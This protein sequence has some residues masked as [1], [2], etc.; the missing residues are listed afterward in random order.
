MKKYIICILTLTIV[1]LACNNKNDDGV[2]STDILQEEYYDVNIA[3]A[4]Q[5]FKT[6]IEKQISLTEVYNSDSSIENF[7]SLQNQW[8]VCAKYFSKVRAYNVVAVKNLFYDVLIYNYEI[9]TESIETNITEQVIFDSTYFNK[10]SSVT[11][12]LGA[13]EYLLYNEQNSNTAFSLLTE[14]SFRKD[15]MLGVCENVLEKTNLLVDFWAGY[16][17][18]FINAT[19][20]SCTT[21]ARCVSFNQ[22]INIIDVI[23]VSKLGKP[24]GFESSDNIN[25]KLL[26]AYRSEHSLELI[27]S[28]L[29]EIEYAY[30]NSTVNF[31][32][33][34]D[35]I[36]D[37]SDVS[38][39]INTTFANINEHISAID[40]SLYTAIL[41]DD[42]NVE[43]L[44]DS[45]LD[46]VKYFS[47]DAASVLS[48]TILPTDN[49]GD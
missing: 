36:A 44:Y 9:N 27:K 15:Y 39:G 28:S 25:T 24:A 14:D 19:G 37:S 49:D 17:E 33:V 43:L 31:S 5:N 30:S 7:E 20:T 8:L 1:V 35:E 42:P 6:S 26:E 22:L 46:L 4:I 29:E 18:T 12:G 48:V 11:K 3:P 16:K 41:N 38:D 32:S 23:R 10:K 34:V 13:L 21:N 45:L 2:S 47:V 40:T